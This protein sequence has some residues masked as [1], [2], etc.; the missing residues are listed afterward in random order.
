MM[1]MLHAHLR[2]DTL[3]L[4]MSLLL[5]VPSVMATAEKLDRRIRSKHC[6]HT[7]QKEMRHL[8]FDSLGVTPSL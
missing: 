3:K 5:E 4:P 7:Q 8:G 2:S 6:T 1:M